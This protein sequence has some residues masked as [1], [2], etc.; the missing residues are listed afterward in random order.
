MPVF[1]EPGPSLAWPGLA[2]AGLLLFN[3]KIDRDLWSHYTTVQYSSV[4]AGLQEGDGPKY[5]GE[6]S[7]IRSEG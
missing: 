7:L 1:G 3:Q 4:Q 6:Q 5:G 2:W